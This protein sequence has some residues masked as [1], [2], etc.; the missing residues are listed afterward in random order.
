MGD[1]ET[2]VEAVQMELACRAYMA[3]PEAVD[4]SN[5]PTAL[6]ATRAARARETLRRVLETILE[7][8]SQ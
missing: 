3:E 7:W 1:P 5:W 8:V 4:P 2:G 6:D